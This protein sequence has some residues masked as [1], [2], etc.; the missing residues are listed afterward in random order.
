[1]ICHD[2]P[3]LDLSD[4]S[5]SFRTTAGSVTVVDKVSLQLRR[6]ET[7]CL[8]GESGSGKTITGRSIIGL[9]PPSPACIRE[10][11]ILLE[12]TGILSLSERD[13]S[14]IRGK[15]IGMIFQDS[16]GALNPVLTV[17]EQIAENLRIHCQ[18]SRRKAFKESIELLDRVGIS[19]P[20]NRMKSYPHEL[21]GGMRQRI[22]IAIALAAKPK[23]LIADEPT[24]ALDV[25]VQAQILNLIK[26]MQLEND[27]AVLFI[28]HDLGVVAEIADKV[29]VMY[30]GQIV[31]YGTARGVLGRPDMPYTQALLNCSPRLDQVK[32]SHAR[33]RSIPGSVLEPRFR[34]NGCAFSNRCEHSRSLCSDAS[35]ALVHRSDGRSV[36]CHYSFDDSN[37]QQTP[38]TT[39]IHF[40]PLS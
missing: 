12:G 17:G 33:L 6:G 35:P 18:M 5:V 25:T 10:G 3:L 29:A 34:D 36:R 37:L 19:D 11:R 20:I 4:L 8:V 1:M 2:R 22:V 9:L 14:Q 13:L 26:S 23:L 31:E 15:E 30:A 7:L 39:R 24:T 32:T 27:M 38:G 21:S 40:A 28:T 16:I